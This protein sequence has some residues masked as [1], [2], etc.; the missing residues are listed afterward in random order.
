M[1]RRFRQ[2]TRKHTNLNDLAFMPGT[3]GT[4]ATEVLSDHSS[5]ANCY[6]LVNAYTIVEAFKNEDLYQ[7]LM[8]DTL[9]CDG[10]PLS[11]FLGKKNQGI[12]QIRGADFMRE[13]LLRSDNTGRHY[14][15]GSTE[16]VLANLIKAVQRLNPKVN[17]AGFHSPAFQ[18]DYQA[19]IP[20]WVNLIRE[21]EASIVWIGLGTPK[22]DFV[23]HEI[24]KLI[25]GNILAVGA[26]FDY[27]AGN[28]SESPKIFQLLYL[29][30][31]WRLMKEPRRLVGR[32]IIGNTKFIHILMQQ[33][34]KDKIKK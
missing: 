22:Q 31:L 33:I 8:K 2:Q 27:L 13:V 28:V 30:W 12:Q 3:L 19:L 15:L 6:H 11:Y 18:I 9:L 17:I 21:S 24:S 34:I 25:S 4:L 26:A 10:K 5:N 32:Y 16:E 23:S 7:I 1:I 29:E 20:A 14:F